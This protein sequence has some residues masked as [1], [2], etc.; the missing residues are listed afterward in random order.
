MCN[1]EETV[2]A[3]IQKIS[4][5]A[6]QQSSSG[7]IIRIDDD[8]DPQGFSPSL[9]FHTIFSNDTLLHFQT[10][11]PKPTSQKPNVKAKAP[12]KRKSSKGQF[13]K[14]IQRRVGEH[15]LTFVSSTTCRIC[16][17]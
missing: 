15:C 1:T 6:Q 5:T 12:Q 3:K 8:S 16:L 13:V 14:L 7:S 17:R 2:P 11:T 9:L 4:G 10:D